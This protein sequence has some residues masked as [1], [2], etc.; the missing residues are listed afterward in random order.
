MAPTLLGRPMY[1]FAKKLRGGI[2][3]RDREHQR[4]QDD[5]AEDDEPDG[6]HAGKLKVFSLIWKK[7]AGIKLKV[8]SSIWKKH[9]GKLKVFFLN[10]EKA[11]F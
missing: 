8:F 4:P 6:Q 1:I 10:L 2:C 3:S 11:T 9:A 7:H 5:D